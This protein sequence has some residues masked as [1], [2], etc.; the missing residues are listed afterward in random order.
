MKRNLKPTRLAR[1]Y[2]H[3]DWCTRGMR[4]RVLIT[5]LVNDLKVVSIVGWC[6]YRRLGLRL[7]GVPLKD[8]MAAIIWTKAYYGLVWTTS[9]PG[10][11]PGRALTASL[12]FGSP[13]LRDHSR[14]RFDGAEL[15]GCE[16]ASQ[17]ANDRC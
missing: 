1:V 17:T 12:G 16:S 9:F 11:R 4:A 3:H 6:L 14:S 10:R 8:D 7:S 5:S 2:P 13:Q 15:I